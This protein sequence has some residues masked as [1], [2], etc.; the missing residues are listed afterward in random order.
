MPDVCEI[1]GGSPGVRA[2]FFLNADEEPVSKVGI[3]CSWKD[4]AGAECPKYDQ[5][6][7]L[8]L[9]KNASGAGLEKI[10]SRAHKKLY[11]LDKSTSV[12]GLKCGGGS[13]L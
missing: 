10:E 5:V 6:R 12:P 7:F 9:F 8:K 13:E 4:R 11:H 2:F 3:I 1:E